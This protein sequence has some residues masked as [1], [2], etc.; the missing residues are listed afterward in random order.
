MT[1]V[2]I[3]IKTVDS[4]RQLFLFINE[5]LVIVLSDNLDNI[6]LAF[7]RIA[8]H[9]GTA[10][11][12]RR[13]RIRVGIANH[14]CIFMVPDIYLGNSTFKEICAALEKF[15]N[16]IVRWKHIT[17]RKSEYVFTV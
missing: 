13:N 8:N 10:Y 14:R 15:A 12:I 16:S 17:T 11:L 6:D 5:N 2:R 7:H 9:Y 1:N 3:S 4:K